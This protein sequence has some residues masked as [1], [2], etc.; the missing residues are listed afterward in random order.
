MVNG[1]VD[2]R[3]AVTLRLACRRDLIHEIRDKLYAIDDF[4]HRITS[5]VRKPPARFH[6][7]YRT[8]N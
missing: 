2:L 3:N 1:I 5:L 7:A 6:F 4:L 8:T